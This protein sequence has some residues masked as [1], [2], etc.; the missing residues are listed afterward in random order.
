MPAKVGYKSALRGDH[1]K[2]NANQPVELTGYPAISLQGIRQLTGAGPPPR[3]TVL[4]SL[5]AG[6]CRRCSVGG[7]LAQH[8]RV[9]RNAGLKTR[10]EAQERKC[11][12]IDNQETRRYTNFLKSRLTNKLGAAEADRNDAYHHR[13]G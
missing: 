11:S 10:L 4:V 1:D 8:G 9:V 6:R 12:V 7:R 2:P 3:V 5:P 13:Q